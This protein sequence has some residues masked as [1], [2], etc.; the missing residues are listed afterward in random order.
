[1]STAAQ[2]GGKRPSTINNENGSF[3]QRAICRLGALFWWFGGLPIDCAKFTP[4]YGFLRTHLAF[5]DGSLVL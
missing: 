1:M 3:T 4:R 5:R 2:I